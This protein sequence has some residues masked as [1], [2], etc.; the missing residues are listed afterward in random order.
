[1]DMANLDNLSKIERRKKKALASRVRDVEKVKSSFLPLHLPSSHT[2]GLFCPT[3]QQQTVSVAYQPISSK[4]PKIQQHYLLHKEFLLLLLSWSL[5]TLHSPPPA[6]VHQ[7]VAAQGSASVMS[8]PALGAGGLLDGRAGDVYCGIAA[9]GT[10]VAVA[11][12]AAAAAA[13]AV[14]ATAV[15]VAVGTAVAAIA[16]GAIAAAAATAAVVFQAVPSSG[17]PAPSPAAVREAFEKRVTIA[18]LLGETCP[19]VPN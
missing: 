12:T 4:M 11:A 3:P 17:A 8:V 13:A 6:L 19:Y 1:M 18:A 16:A 15:G 5:P 2:K 10:A 14:A 9:S 7:P